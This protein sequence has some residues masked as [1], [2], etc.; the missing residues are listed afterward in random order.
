MPLGVERPG[1][2]DVVAVPA[3]AAVDDRVAGRQQ[4]RER[5][6]VSPTNAAGHHHPDVARRVERGDQLL[7][8]AAHRARPRPR[9]A[10][11]AAGLTSYTTH[12]CPARVKPAHHVGAHPAETDHPELHDA[13]GCHVAATATFRIDEHRAIATCDET[14]AAA[15]RRTQRSS[16]T[17]ADLSEQDARSPVGAARGGPSGTCSPTSP[18]TPTRSRGML[19]GAQRG[20]VV[21]QYPSPEARTVDIDAGSD[22][23]RGRARPTICATRPNGSSAGGTSSTRTAWQRHGSTLR[24]P[25]AD[26]D[27]ARHAGGG[28]WRCTT[29]TSG[30]GGRGSAGPTSSSASSWCR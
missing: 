17:I 4:R 14:S 21:A 18:A 25:A 6:I 19:A 13:S 30:S 23:G 16:P 1:S 10:A 15:E 29:P 7:E 22:A 9:I 11:T 8:R 27:G 20:E 12:S 5:A 2:I 26:V 3:V 28:R 24:R